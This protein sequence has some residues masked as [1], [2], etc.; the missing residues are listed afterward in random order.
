[1]NKKLGG[2]SLVEVLI[3]VAII[4]ILAA[5]AM[6]SN[7]SSLQKTRRAAAKIFLLE[8]QGKQEI[9]YLRRDDNNKYRYSSLSGLRY[10]SDTLFIDAEGNISSSG[11]AFYRIEILDGD[12]SDYTFKITATPINTQTKDS[13]GVLTVDHTGKKTATGSGSCW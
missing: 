3:V 4:G 5:F 8:I 6:S 7:E 2:F 10:D 11:Q 12:L 9:A 13:C 1:M